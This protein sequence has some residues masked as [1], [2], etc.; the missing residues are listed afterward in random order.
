MIEPWDGTPFG[1]A[2]LALF[3][4]ADLL[5]YLRD[6]RPGLPWPGHWD[7]P[8]GGR[9][10]GET[11]LDCVLRETAEEF[12]LALP[13]SALHWGRAHDAGLAATWFFVARQPEA[14]AGRIVFGE[15]GQVWRLVPAEAFLGSRTAIPPLQHRLRAALACGA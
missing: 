6:E 8:G 7:L 13:A 11:P 14:L 9:E 1:G 15:E 10:A 3:L 4:G 5:V 2:K 12:G